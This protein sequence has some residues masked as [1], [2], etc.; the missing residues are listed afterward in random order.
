VFAASGVI[1]HSLAFWLGRID[2][3]A[4]SVFDFLVTFSIYPRPLFGG[5]LKIVL[6]TLLPA[7]FIGY[8]PYELLRDFQ[9]TGLAAACGGAA[10]YAALALAVFAAG[11]RRYESGNRFGVRI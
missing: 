4:R 8:L 3:L 5:L 6:F 10:A 7:G 11:L 1:L 2:A 9:W